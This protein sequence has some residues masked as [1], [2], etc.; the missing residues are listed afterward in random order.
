MGMKI[1]GREIRIEDHYLDKV[2]YIP[3]HA[4]G[5]AG[6]EDCEQGVIIEIREYVVMVLYCKGRTVQA[7]DPENLVWG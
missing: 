3:N 7:T 2:T 5:N 4:N 6:H 1:E